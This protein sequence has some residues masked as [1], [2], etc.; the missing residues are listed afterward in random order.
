MTKL[1]IDRENNGYSVNYIAE[2]VDYRNVQEIFELITDL[3]DRQG[4]FGDGD[5]FPVYK[6]E[7]HGYF[8]EGE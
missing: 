8:K 6:I 4:S 7:F 2:K 1:N 5:G 3:Y